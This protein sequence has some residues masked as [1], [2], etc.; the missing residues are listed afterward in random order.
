[1]TPAWQMLRELAAAQIMSLCD[2]YSGFSHLK[3]GEVAKEMYTI[4]T[5]LGMAQWL[6]M[7]QGPHNG[8]TEFQAAVNEVFWELISRGKIRLFVDDGAL[9]A[10]VYRPGPPPVG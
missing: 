1:M 5:S 9:R 6:V 10:G 3:M 8:P 4:S 2:A 7:P